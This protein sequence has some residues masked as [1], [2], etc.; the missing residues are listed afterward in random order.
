M[1]TCAAA[2]EDAQSDGAELIMDGGATFSCV[3]IDSCQSGF[4]L[5]PPADLT[6]VS[7]RAR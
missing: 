4:W 1:A 3:V 5:R 2:S 7:W 6:Y